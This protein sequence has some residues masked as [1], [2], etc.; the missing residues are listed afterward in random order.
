MLILQFSV[1]T[2]SSIAPF[3][4]FD[5]LQSCP[6]NFTDF[7]RPTVRT[8]RRGWGGHRVDTVRLTSNCLRKYV[9][10]YVTQCGCCSIAVRTHSD[11]QLPTPALPRCHFV[12]LLTTAVISAVSIVRK[13]TLRLSEECEPDLSSFTFP[14]VSP[15]SAVKELRSCQWKYERW[16]TNGKHHPLKLT[17]KSVVDLDSCWD[18]PIVPCL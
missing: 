14:Y 11:P 3:F 7:Q 18:K 1:A 5:C 6:T 13:S 15:A 12:A 16:S 10:R 4:D 17:A 8:G 9:F 2:D